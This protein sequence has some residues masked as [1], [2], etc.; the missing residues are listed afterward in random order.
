MVSDS[1]NVA[2]VGNDNRQLGAPIDSMQNGNIISWKDNV[3]QN[4]RLPFLYAFRI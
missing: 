3:E 1:I 4:S 2:P